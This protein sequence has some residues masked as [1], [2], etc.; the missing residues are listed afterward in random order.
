ML[1]RIKLLNVSAVSFVLSAI[2]LG[3]ALQIANGFFNMEALKWLT[4]ALLLCSLGAITQRRSLFLSRESVV[5]VSVLLTAG[6]AWQLFVLHTNRPGVYQTGRESIATFKWLIVCQGIF[7]LL[8]LLP[9]RRLRPLWFPAVLVTGLGLG[10]WMIKASPEPYIDVVVVHKEAIDALLDDRDPYRMSF[11]NVYSR[12]DA[13]RFY[14]PEALIGDRVAFGYPYPPAS[15]LLA[16]PGQL[17]F[18]DYRYAEL[19]FL[20][21]AAALL[22]YSQPTLVAKL[23]ACLLLTTP[24]VWF[25]VEQG[26]TEPIAL[27]TLALTV[28]LIVRNPIAAGWAAGLM[29]VTKQYLGFSGLAILR[30]LL[31]RPRQWHWAALGA[32][33][34]ACAITLP[35]ALWHPN[36]FMRSVIFLQTKEPF[37]IDSL[38]YLS[39]AAQR[40]LG[41]GSFLW[42]VGAATI[43]AVLSLFTTR[44]TAAGFATSIALTTFMMFA[45]GSKAFCNYYFFVVGALCCAVAAI[46]WS[47]STTDVPR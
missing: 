19:L 42:A 21:A 34:A 2:A 3:Y 13:A 41:Q 25:V 45:F 4:G 11:A 17:L 47:R 37:R 36:A 9:L 14:N 24:R 29:A 20:I 8:G 32:V 28:F 33:V 23:S 40:G 12:E 44:N 39:W 30:L 15:L 16:V 38:S 10:M 5:M 18:G 1:G 7:V 26:W 27:F 6:I 46:P 22:G 43:A 35:L 31:L